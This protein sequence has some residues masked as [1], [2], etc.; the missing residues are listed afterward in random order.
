MNKL[1]RLN[2]IRER[3]NVKGIKVIFTK[4]LN[5]GKS[6]IIEEKKLVKVHD[7]DNSIEDEDK[8]GITSQLKFERARV[9]TELESEVLLSNAEKFQLKLDLDW[10][11][12]QTVKKKNCALILI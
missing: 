9:K 1:D 7:D 8:I 3:A 12:W 6:E 11:R 2:F 5:P 10:A 4:I